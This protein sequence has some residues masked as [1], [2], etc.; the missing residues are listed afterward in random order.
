MFFPNSSS[1][2]GNISSFEFHVCDFA[3]HLVPMEDT[4][5]HIIRTNHV[6]HLRLFIAMRSIASDEIGS[7]HNKRKREN[8]VPTATTSS[9]NLAPSTSGAAVRCCDTDGY[10]S[11][12][13]AGNPLTTDISGNRSESSEDLPSSAGKP[14]TPDVS[15]KSSDHIVLNSPPAAGC[16]IAKEMT[17]SLSESHDDV[18]SSAGTPRSSDVRR[19]IMGSDLVAQCMECAGIIDAMDYLRDLSED[20]IFFNLKEDTAVPITSAASGA[21]P[22]AYIP[23]VDSPSSTTVEVIRVHRGRVFHDLIEYHIIHG[24]NPKVTYEFKVINSYGRE[25]Q[26][27]DGGGVMRDVLT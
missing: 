3:K 24:L 12:P 4:V 23:P 11:A 22:S 5:D 26:A 15:L 2:K 13:A 18:P 6:A 20:K 8:P 9:P 25:E 7:P 10:H 1:P 14:R 27:E 19:H 21:P 17:Q 16:P